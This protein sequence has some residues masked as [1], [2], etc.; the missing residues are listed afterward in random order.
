MG[1]NSAR[2]FLFSLSLVLCPLW[3]SAL[4]QEA[5]GEQA[6]LPPGTKITIQ[7]WQQYKQFMPDGMVAL[8]EGNYLYR[9]GPRA[10]GA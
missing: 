6:A 9:V 7:N 8:F 3:S 1:L 10:G 5:A 4:S 2:R